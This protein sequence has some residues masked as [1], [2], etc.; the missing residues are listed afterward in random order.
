M[1]CYLDDGKNDSQQKPSCSRI[2]KFPSIFSTAWIEISLSI[3]KTSKGR[4]QMELNLPKLSSSWIPRPSEIQKINVS[5]MLPL[6]NVIFAYVVLGPDSL[7]GW[8][9]IGN[10]FISINVNFHLF[11]F[12]LTYPQYCVYETRC[13]FPLNIYWQLWN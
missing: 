11:L 6:Y 7:G 9:L 8:L 5:V 12:L 10:Y 2:F 13:K 3:A 4:H 1:F